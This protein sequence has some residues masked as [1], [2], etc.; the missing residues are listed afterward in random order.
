[1]PALTKIFILILFAAH[2]ATAASA[3]KE[4]K[5]DRLI[6]AC[7][8]W[9]DSRLIAEGD[10]L[11][12]GGNMEK[13]LVMYLI[14]CNRADNPKTQA[15]ARTRVSAYLKA[16][17]AYYDNGNYSKAQLFYLDGLKVAEAAPTRPYVAEL[18]KNMGNV[19]CM[20]QDY[21]KGLHLYKV[22]V[23][24]G[25]ATGDNET[26]YKIYQNM[27]GAYIYKNDPDNAR[28]YYDK[29]RMTT[30]KVTRITT[31]M[32]GYTHALLIK[33]EG[34]ADSAVE[35]FRRLAAYANTFGMDPRYECSAYKEAYEIYEETG[36]Y[37]SAIVYI[38]RCKN[39]AESSRLTHMFVDTYKH[40]ADIYA[41]RGQ[42]D[43]ALT[44]KS[45]YLD[46]KDSIFNVR[47]FDMAKNQQFIYETE[48]AE[49]DI[50]S[51]N[52]D[53]ERRAQVI[54]N[55]RLVILC[56]TVGTVIVL[57][58][59]LYVYRQKQRLSESYRSMFQLNKQLSENYRAAKAQQKRMSDETSPIK[60]TKECAPVHAD[61]P[62]GQMPLSSVPPVDSD[63]KYKNSSL[64]DEQRER[65]ADAITDVMDNSEEFC[66]PDFSL[67][68]LARL[69]GSNSN[70]VSQTINVV[71]N[72]NFS[73]YV[74]EYRVRLACTR[75]SDSNS[76][77]QYTIRSIGES[78]G[79][80][81][82]G[83]FINV[84]K[85]YTGMTPS[86]YQKIAKEEQNNS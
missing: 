45:E 74:N 34:H 58:L 51:L 70:Y 44:L 60:A 52:R 86:L 53:K 10:R 15:E 71:Y 65:L 29:A 66:N 84:F 85:R 32:D 54:R 63:S 59:L 2:M 57:L 3:A 83:T 9:A 26:L 12:A 40:L 72:K 46:I 47:E 7:S 75:L 41:R 73:N 50:A 48:K 55:Q 4:T 21:E 78:V 64:N 68:M 61:L 77:G 35:E 5:Y 76:Y 6:N 31:F 27:V 14:V 25:M 62:T 43:K 56:T 19:Y 38:N 23:K 13:A 36:R 16:G 11:L 82:Y 80:S 1:M 33:A 8:E 37:D 49:R 24:Q 69:V 39:L 42:T 28:L 18:Y 81:V 79:F 30:H 20:F 67:D 22:G 17:N